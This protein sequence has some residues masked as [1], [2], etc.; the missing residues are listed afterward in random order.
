M[1]KE[2]VSGGYIQWMSNDGKSFFPSSTTFKLITPGVYSVEQDFQRGLYF[3]R[4]PISVEGIIRLPDTNSDKVIDEIKRFWD[5]E[6]LFRKSGLSYKRG[7]LMH[8]PPG[9][10]KSVTLRVICNDVVNRGG[11]VIQFKNPDILSIGLRVLREIQPDTPVVVTMED[12]DSLVER[13]I[14]SDVINLLDGVDRIDRVIFLA[15]TNYP[16]KLGER[17]VNRPS[18]FDRRFYIGTPNAESRKIYFQHIF[19]R[20]SGIDPDKV[21]L[22][23]INQWVKDTEGMSIAHLKELY[24]AVVIIGT[25]YEEA[26]ETLRAMSVLPNS[27]EYKQSPRDEV[28]DSGSKARLKSLQKIRSTVEKQ[29]T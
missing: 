18:R 1:A 10:G 17:I 19:S 5:R 8:G 22:A 12:L 29:S 2:K 28:V 23:H 6:D 20:E 24:V 21:A 7:I 25:P 4:V 9:S 11:I 15:T 14:E 16:E 27:S 13:Y 3:S 26:V